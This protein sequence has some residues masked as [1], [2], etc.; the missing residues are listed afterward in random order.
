MRMKDQIKREEMRRDIEEAKKHKE[1]LTREEE[2]IKVKEAAKRDQVKK[3]QEANLQ[4]VLSKTK[5]RKLA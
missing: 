2:Q 3:V 4:V 1:Y 5:E